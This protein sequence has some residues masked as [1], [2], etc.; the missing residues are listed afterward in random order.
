LVESQWLEGIIIVATVMFDPQEEEIEG[1][2][3]F[4]RQESEQHHH[5]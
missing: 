5:V 1:A 4:L 3:R 2:D